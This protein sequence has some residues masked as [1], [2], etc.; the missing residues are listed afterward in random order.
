M[1][2]KVHKIRVHFCIS[3]TNK[4]QTKITCVAVRKMAKQQLVN[5]FFRYSYLIRDLRVLF[6][7]RYFNNYYEFP[8]RG[9]PGPPPPSPYPIASRVRTLYDF[10]CRRRNMP[11]Y[12][13]G[14]S[15]W[16]VNFLNICSRR[17]N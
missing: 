2:Y 7:M 14:L 5:S 4:R 6:I 3:L 8:G 10:A 1:K 17:K 9:C 12:P 11:L 15:C 13:Q 16:I